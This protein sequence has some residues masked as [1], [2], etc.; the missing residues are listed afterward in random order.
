VGPQGD[1]GSPGPAGPAGL[2]GPPGI[3]LD[4]DATIIQQINWDPFGRVGTGQFIE[5][6]RQ[7]TF[8]FSKPLDPAAVKRVTSGIVRVAFR[9][10]DP[11]NLRLFSI[12]GQARLAQSD[13]IEW[14]G[15][16]DEQVI[17][18]QIR[19]QGTA[20]I[21]LLCDYIMDE[22]GRPVS[23]SAAFLLKKKLEGY[24]PGGIFATWLQIG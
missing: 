23:G 19:E 22:N 18:G 14:Q 17:S 13:I 21:D 24:P 3:G 12:P 4:P 20:F 15:S 10:D 16:F 8:R 7:M 2:P 9:S 5:I 11:K 1:A 6:L